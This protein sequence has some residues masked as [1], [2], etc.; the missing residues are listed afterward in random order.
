[1]TI[2]KQDRQEFKSFCRQATDT[3]IKNIYWKEKR[4]AE[5]DEDKEIYAEIALA[6]IERRGLTI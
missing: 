4:G 3:Q 5:E 6:E 1:M 2:T